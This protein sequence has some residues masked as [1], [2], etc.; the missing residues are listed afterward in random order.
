M[1]T[2]HEIAKLSELSMGSLGDYL[3]KD[4]SS[5]RASAEE[6]KARVDSTDVPL[7]EEM[8]EHYRESAENMIELADSI[9]ARSSSKERK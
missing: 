6:M 3:A 7:S 8:K 2:A 5:L 4:S 1:S 9:D